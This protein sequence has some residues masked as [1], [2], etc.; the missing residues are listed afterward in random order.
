MTD[1][2]LLKNISEVNKNLY[3][4]CAIQRGLI[5]MVGRLADRVSTLENKR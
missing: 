5:R 2:D 1:R 3:E 4:A